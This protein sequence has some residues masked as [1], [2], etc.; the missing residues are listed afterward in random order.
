MLYGL[1]A[2]PGINPSHLTEPVLC[3][4]LHGS[5]EAQ[6]IQLPH[7]QLRYHILSCLVGEIFAN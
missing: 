3:L 4:Q 5:A 7:L 1:H 6:V 2:L